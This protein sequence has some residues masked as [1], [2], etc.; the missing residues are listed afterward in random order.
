MRN[1]VFKN[2]P[3]VIGEYSVK[4]ISPDEVIVTGAIEPFNFVRYRLDKHRSKFDW[5]VVKYEQGNLHL[6]CVKK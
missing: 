1:L 6:S 3:K 2:L 5:Q 4:R